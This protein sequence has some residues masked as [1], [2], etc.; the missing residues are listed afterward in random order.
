[1]RLSRNDSDIVRN[2][3]AFKSYLADCLEREE[4]GSPERL[5][6]LSIR[7]IQELNEEGCRGICLNHLA[8]E[9]DE[10]LHCRMISK[11]IQQEFQLLLTP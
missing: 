7:A 3:E 1:M 5:L 6:E 11:G 8:F 2:E 9:F 4:S 10:L